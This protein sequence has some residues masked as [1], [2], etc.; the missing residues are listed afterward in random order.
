MKKSILIFLLIFVFSISFFAQSDG[1]SAP[2]KWEK[3]KISKDNIEIMFP[4]LPVHLDSVNLCKQITTL[5]YYAFA[6]E[7]VYKLKVYKKSGFKFPKY[8]VEKEKFTEKNFSERVDEIK[9]EL[10]N[11]DSQLVKR[12]EKDFIKFEKQDDGIKKSIFLFNDYKNLRWFEFEVTTYEG[13]ESKDSQFI[14][15]LKLSA[16]SEAIEI[17]NGSMS[18][19]GDDNISLE[20]SGEKNPEIKNSPL[21]LIFKPKPSYTDLARQSNTVGTVKLR[22]TFLRNGGVGSVSVVEALKNGLTE[23]AVAAAKK[24]AFLPKKSDGQT[25]S[26]TR[27]VVY[28]FL[29]Y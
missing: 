17:N 20:N 29:I 19:L 5:T 28:S 24:M 12:G 21:K 6:E 10:K 27:T 9:T 7:T 22:V 1:N 16:S 18:V 15:S 4:K 8:C 13:I 11:K 2:V 23:Q 14:D 25:V 3:Y 26:V